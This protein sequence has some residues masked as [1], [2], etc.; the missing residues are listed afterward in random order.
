MLFSLTAAVRRRRTAPAGPGVTEGRLPS[1]SIRHHRVSM[2]MSS[3]GVITSIIARLLCRDLVDELA[4]QFQKL[5]DEIVHV[6]LLPLGCLWRRRRGAPNSA[7][8]PIRRERVASGL[9][10]RIGE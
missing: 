2:M 7:L 10:G 3:I 9:I 8:R 4:D 1:G 6:L 5:K